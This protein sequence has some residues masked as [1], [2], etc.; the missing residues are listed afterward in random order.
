MEPPLTQK[1]EQINEICSALNREFVEIFLGKEY[2]VIEEFINNELSDE[3]STPHKWTKVLNS[4]H[5]HVVS[6]EFKGSV[7]LMYE[8]NTQLSDEHR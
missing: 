7:P 5:L 6:E 3:H 8:Y 1:Q 2:S 4:Y